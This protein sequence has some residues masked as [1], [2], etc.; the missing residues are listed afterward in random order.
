[1]YRTPTL[2]KKTL[3]IGVIALFIGVCVFQNISGYDKKSNILLIKK[4]ANYSPINYDYIN[5]YWKACECNETTLWDCSSHNYNGTIY[6]ANWD[7]GCCLD[8]DGIDDYVDLTDHVKEIAINKT[9]DCNITFYFKSISTSD[10][11]ILSYTG[12]YYDWDPEFRIELKENGSIL[13]KFGKLMCYIELFS[14]GTYNDGSLHFVKILLNQ[15]YASSTVEIYIDGNLDASV[16]KYVCDFYNTDFDKATIGKRASDNSDFFK[17][18]IDELK[19]IKYEGGNQPPIIEINGSTY[20]ETYHE[21]EF[22]IIIYDSEGD[23]GWIKIDWGDGNITDWLGPYKSGEQFNI[24]HT[25][26][27]EGAYCICGKTKDF[28][29]ESHWSE[30]LEIK[31]GNQSPENPTIFGPKYGDPNEELTYY[32][33]SSDYEGD[34]LYYFIDWDDG[35]NTDWIGP[36]PSNETITNIHSW[37]ENGTYEI[38]AKAKDIW[39]KESDWSSYLIKIGDFN[40]DTSDIIIKGPTQGRPRITYYYNFTIVDYDGEPISIEIDW[41][42]GTIQEFF[43]EPEPYQYVTIGHCWL[44]KGV[45]IIQARTKDIFGFFGTWNEFKVNIPRSRA[46]SLYLYHWLFDRIPMLKILQNLLI[47]T[48]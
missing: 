44:K 33:T 2:F 8:F 5:T 38:R 1:M 23:E 7:P 10:G 28:W 32:F 27:Y 35:N 41:G 3:V 30:C 25:W 39:D 11:I 19:F 12:N 37:S 40:N 14:N 13:F 15:D 48:I 24:S 17:G 22:S 34:D 26:I 4:I 16:T 42:D 47:L 21:I 29:S 43:Y 18:Q 31:I 36:H 20:G 6:G 9:D 46:R 45:Y